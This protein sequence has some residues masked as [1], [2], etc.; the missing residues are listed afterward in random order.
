MIIQQ[1]QHVCVSSINT[2]N[3]MYILKSIHIYI[4]IYIINIYIYRDTYEYYICMQM[5]KV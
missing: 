3:S 4:Y 5:L 2:H 1:Q